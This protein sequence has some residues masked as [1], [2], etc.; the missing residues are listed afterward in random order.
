MPRK[1]KTNLDS[2]IEEKLQYLGLTLDNIPEELQDE[3]ISYR[4]PRDYEEKQY[5]QYKYCLLYTS[6]SPRDS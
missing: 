4:V 6:P 1:K 3:P 5:K 2:E